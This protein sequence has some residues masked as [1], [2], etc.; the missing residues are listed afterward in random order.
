MGTVSTARQHLL[1]LMSTLLAATMPK[2]GIPSF[3]SKQLILLKTEVC[4]LVSGPCWLRTSTIL[5]LKDLGFV[6]NTHGHCLFSLPGHPR[7]R[8][9]V[10]LDLDDDIEGGGEY[11]QAT[12]AKMHASCAERNFAPRTSPMEL[13]GRHNWQEGDRSVRYTMHEFASRLAPVVVPREW[14]TSAKIIDEVMLMRVKGVMGGLN[15]IAGTGRLDF[16]AAASTSPVAYKIC[17]ATSRAKTTHGGVCAQ[18][19]RTSH[20]R[21]A[22]RCSAKPSLRVT[23]VLKQHVSN[24]R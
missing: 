16:A 23:V 7:N 11:L 12:V 3:N 10:L 13:F 4:G 19:A 2:D 17:W 22:V 14:L 9:V 24:V 8:G 15:W 1:S 6:E 5:K 20:A 21:L 18:Q